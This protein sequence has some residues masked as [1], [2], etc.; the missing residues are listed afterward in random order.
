MST[1]VFY[2]YITQIL[3]LFAQTYPEVVGIHMQF[4]RVH[5]TEWR[6]GGLDVVHVLDGSLQTSH[7]S[8]PVSCHLG[9]T[10]DRSG[11]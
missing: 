6:I 11:A 8:P 3:V 10:H 9:V 2:I 1:T 5:H 4:L 7:H